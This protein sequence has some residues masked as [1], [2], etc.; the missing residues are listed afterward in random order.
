MRWIAAL[1]MYNVSAA[2]ARDWRGLLTDVRASLAPWLDA[3][4]DTLE[5]VDPGADLTAFWPRDDLLLAQTCGYPLTHALV[6][7][8][9]LVATPVFDAPGC[10][11]ATYRS[12]LVVRHDLH[13][14][15]LED[16]RGLRAIYNSDD[17]NS[18]MNLLRHA[19]APLA[20]N[21]RFFSSVERSG[22]HLASLQALAVDGRA[23]LAA[24]DCVTYAFARE[25]RPELTAGVREIGVSASTPGL[26]FIT[27]MRVSE[28]DADLIAR[29][30]ADA[31]ARDAARARRLRL[32]GFARTPLTDYA[33]IDDYERQAISLGYPLLA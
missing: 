4:G 2:L 28:H 18:G 22:G 29:A 31:L 10:V 16:C 23:D 25:H 5:L 14:A 3:R 20:R 12:V 30:L 7:R 21:G 24:I 9:R 17:S 11:G 13:A 6:A 19:A 27:S 32:T 15:T 8:V 26:P 33:I 1:P